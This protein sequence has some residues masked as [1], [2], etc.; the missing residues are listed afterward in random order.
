LSFVF[1]LF[2]PHI[3]LS[4]FGVPSFFRSVVSFPVSV[5]EQA[6]EHRGRIEALGAGRV[7]AVDAASTFSR[8][9]PRLVDGVELLAHLF[10]PGRVGPPAGIGFAALEP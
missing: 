3:V 9:G 6:R 8:P 4:S 5:L 1:C 10:H 2:L 7:F